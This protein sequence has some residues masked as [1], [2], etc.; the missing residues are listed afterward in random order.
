M[1]ASK[2]PTTSVSKREARRRHSKMQELSSTINGMECTKSGLLAAASHK[3]TIS[4]MAELLSTNSLCKKS[5]QSVSKSLPPASYEECKLKS[6]YSLYD[7]GIMSKRKYVR[8]VERE[9]AEF[10]TLASRGVPIHT[11]PKH[12]PYSKIMEV[13][14]D[15]E[16]PQLFHCIDPST[17]VLKYRLKDIIPHILAV[18]V[19]MGERDPSTLNWFGK[20]K[21][22]QLAIGE[23]GAPLSRIRNMHVMLLSVL[24][25]TQSVSSP[26]RN[27][28]IMAGEC[29]EN[30]IRLNQYYNTLQTEID[31]LAISG[32][33]VNGTHYGLEVSLYPADQKF[34]A[35]LAGELNNAATYPSP[36]A[37]L[38]KK[39]LASDQ[40]IM[41]GNFNKWRPWGYTQR[42]EVA[43]KVLELKKK[44]PSR[45]KITELIAKNNS[46]QEF[47]PLIGK[48]VD[49]FML[50][51]LHAKNNA[52]KEY[53]QQLFAEA[54]KISSPAALKDPFKAGSCV[55]AFLTCVSSSIGRVGNS[56]RKALNHQN[57]ILGKP[58]EIRFTGEDSFKL[59]KSFPALTTIL[60]EHT[61]N[62]DALLRIHAL[63]E[64]GVHLV[65]VC[66]WIS[67]VKTSEAILLELEE[68]CTVYF[69]IHNFYLAR[70]PL[71]VWT[72]G[73]IAPSH[74]RRIWHK[75]GCGLGLNSAQGREAK[76]QHV[77]NFVKH[78]TIKDRWQKVF[79]HDFIETVY[80]PLRAGAKSPHQSSV[81]FN[82]KA[83]ESCDRCGNKV[84]P[85]RFCTHPVRALIFDSAKQGRISREAIYKLTTLPS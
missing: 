48:H 73:Y 4:E 29:A 75:F 50:E 24:N 59:A 78:S 6:L 2:T 5:L 40:G 37:D 54:Q 77:K 31:E 20:P 38:N 56:L 82:G 76:H 57:L 7:E 83:P 44:N 47:P 18:Y 1:R 25:S 43:A 65:N 49:N 28:I 9:T 46:R 69:N 61:Q 32:V 22:F 60:C 23:D 8:I 71:C 36:Y 35:H 34:H 80:L 41:P 51:P 3:T 13:V 12:L 68:A 64:L 52:M 11:I 27:H 79:L 85:C 53:F 33:E 72:L 58:I 45:T 26:K 42:L 66:A 70:N 39:H 21:I 62:P 17:P 81:Q 67:G 16:R 10:K 19:N 63:H 15:V 74:A 30:D 55:A 14:K 84:T